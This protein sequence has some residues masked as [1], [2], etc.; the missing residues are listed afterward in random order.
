MKLLLPKKLR[1]SFVLRPATP[2]DWRDLVAFLVV[3][4]LLLL[5]G[6]WLGKN[7]IFEPPAR[8]LGDYLLRQRDRV[9]P[10]VTR[11]V[12]IDEEDQD[13]V[14]GGQ[15]PVNGISLVNG[16]CTLLK[17]SP[18]LLV[19]DIDTGSK[20]SFPE[21][22]RL[23]KMGAPVIWA[24]DADWELGQRGLN[25]KPGRLIGGRLTD[26]PPYGIARMP[27][28]FD[29]VVRGWERSFRVDGY[30][31]ASLTAA[32][33]SQF[34]NKVKCRESPETSFGREYLFAKMNLRE[35]IKDVGTKVPDECP[36]GGP[37]E[38]DPRLAGKIVVLGAFDSH[39]DRHD[40]PWGT[41]Y[42][43]ELVATAIEEDLN[44]DGLAHLPLPA[45]WC[46]KALI[47]LGITM[48]H[49]YFRPLW[50]SVFTLLLLPIAVLISGFSIFYFGDYDLGV[51]PL[52]VGILLE[53]LV[54]SVEKADHY[55]RCAA[56]VHTP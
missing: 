1:G 53:Q 56:D 37:S 52:I 13:Q 21:G 43:A 29:G 19:V 12:R 11:I 51:V 47:A 46:L 27:V 4:T 5:T 36:V 50:A 49:H 45:K 10:R 35:F 54:T 55:A 23:P 26:L 3:L 31:R 15:T 2:K 28:G 32:A 33:V 44:P 18:A 17:S 20:K 22:F 6:D 7:F 24:V 38:G 41:K 48:L 40:T 8:W 16:V 9:Q 30:E 14:L 34:C 39:G 42:G 25:L